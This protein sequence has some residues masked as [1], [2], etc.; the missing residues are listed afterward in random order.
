[1]ISKVLSRLLLN[2]GIKDLKLMDSFINPTLDKLYNPR[3]MKDMEKGVKIL[4]ESILNNEKIRICGDYDQDGNSAILTLY[5]GITRC[6]GNVDYVIPHRIIDGYG[7]NER[8][9]E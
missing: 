6:G 3:L 4:K 2:R 8:I 1:N 5:K 9:V 7:I